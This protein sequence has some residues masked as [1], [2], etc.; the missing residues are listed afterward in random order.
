M[1]RLIALFLLIVGGPALGGPQVTVL[2]PISGAMSPQSISDSF[3]GYASVRAALPGTPIS[4][5][6]DSLYTSDVALLV[7]DATHGPLPENRE[8]TLATRQARVPYVIVL[9]TNVDALYD[10][11]G[12]FD[13]DELLVL[14]EQEIRAVLE[15]YGIGG[16]ETAVYHDSSRAQRATSTMIGDLRRLASDLSALPAAERQNKTL[17]NARAA[18][19]EVYLLTHEESNGQAVT[20]EGTRSLKL[21]IGGKAT[22]AAVS[23]DGV[24]GPGDMISFRYRTDISMPAAAGA[25]MILIDNDRI[26][27]VGVV[28]TVTA[29]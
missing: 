18:D 29:R 7:L 2:L 20:I 22:T 23:V 28:A 24:A 17:P 26:V 27:G 25:R 11:V 5:V 13:G 4:D 12:K 14:E 19:G 1:K 15:L 21:W 10:A 8:H 3:R 9:I 16:A 6:A